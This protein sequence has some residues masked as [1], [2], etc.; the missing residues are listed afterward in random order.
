[1]ILYRWSQICEDSLKCWKKNS[2][3]I[4]CALN[5]LEPFSQMKCLG[6]FFSEDGKSNKE[7]DHRKLNGYKV[8][9][10]FRSHV[11]NKNELST[12][13]KL[14]IHTMNFMDQFSD[15]LSY[16]DGELDPFFNKILMIW[17]TFWCVGHLDSNRFIDIQKYLSW[18]LIN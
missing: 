14:M 12:G 16:M 7:F 2:K 9:A 17:M 1:M 11:F 5:V 13:T 15:R 10:Q 18:L 3:T 4:N 6:C 8:A